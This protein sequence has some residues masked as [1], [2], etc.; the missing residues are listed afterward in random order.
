MALYVTIIELSRH[1]LAYDA[2]HAQTSP[3]PVDITSWFAN[4]LFL[5]LSSLV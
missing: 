4:L 2:R 5:L 3:Y 1:E